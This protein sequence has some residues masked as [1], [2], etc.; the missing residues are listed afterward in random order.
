MLGDVVVVRTAKQ[1]APYSPVVATQRGPPERDVV[2]GGIELGE[3][4]NP[5]LPV[6]QSAGHAVECPDFDTAL[7]DLL[8][9]DVEDALPSL[10]LDLEAVIFL[11]LVLVDLEDVSGIASD[12]KYTIASVRS[13]A[14]QYHH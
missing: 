7:V 6:A 1:L 3:Y 10:G 4:I 2:V 11:M 13:V 9:L 5:L 8:R 12:C 14:I